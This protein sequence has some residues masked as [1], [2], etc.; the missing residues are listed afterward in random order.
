MLLAVPA[1]GG[2]RV[3]L[4]RSSILFTVPLI[5]GV[6]IAL[7][8]KS[9]RPAVIVLGF[10]MLYLLFA[11]W[12]HARAMAAQEQL[13]A[14][15]HVTDAINPRVLPQVGGVLCYRSIYIHDGRIF[16]DALRPTYRLA[17]RRSRWASLPLVDAVDLKPSPPNA[18]ML[19]DFDT[20]IWFTDGFVAALLRGQSAGALRPAA[21]T[22]TPNGSES[23]WGLQLEGTP[24]NVPEWQLEFPDVLHADVAAGFGASEGVY[25]AGGDR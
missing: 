7:K 18:A 10:S 14:S 8:R 12:Q 19:L 11:V 13:L 22:T 5:V 21:H 3:I 15:R 2:M 1:I 23:V 24:D 17:S 16:F 25:A 4:W 20:F 9:V 6:L